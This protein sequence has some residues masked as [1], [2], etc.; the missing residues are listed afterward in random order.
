MVFVAKAGDDET[1]FAIV[2]AKLHKSNRQN[3]KVD[4]TIHRCVI[5]KVPGSFLEVHEVIQPEF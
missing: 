3:V 2:S 4:R 5:R 1:V